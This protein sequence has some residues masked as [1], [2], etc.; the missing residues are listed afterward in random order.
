[1]GLFNRLTVGLFKANK[2]IKEADILF[3]GTLSKEN[4][5]KEQL[6]YDSSSTIQLIASWAIMNTCRTHNLNN[7]GIQIVLTYLDEEFSLYNALYYD[8]LTGF[9]AQ[10]NSKL[11]TIVNIGI[12][13]AYKYYK[14]IPLKPT[15]TEQIISIS[16]I[17]EDVADMVT[18]ELIVQQ[19]RMDIAQT[20]VVVD[21]DIEDTKKEEPSEAFLKAKEEYLKDYE[22]RQGVLQNHRLTIKTGISSNRT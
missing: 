5:L 1:M 13:E 15:F 12:S 10:Y 8:V 14:Q 3:R 9:A 17:L 2:I 19:H 21:D 6:H 22:K 7:E 4:E 16:I 18:N 20:E 11:W